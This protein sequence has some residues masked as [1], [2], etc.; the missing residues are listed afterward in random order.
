MSSGIVWIEDTLTPG[1]RSFP[2]KLE[3]AIDSVMEY[4]ANEAQSYMRTNAPWQDQTGN[5]RQGLFAQAGKDGPHHF[6]VLYHTMP[7]G[8]FLEISHDAQYAIIEPTIQSQGPKV[9]SDIRDVLRR[10]A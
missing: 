6:I 9:M 1:I 4:N 8:I 5:A 3:V 10:V 7:Y 2:A